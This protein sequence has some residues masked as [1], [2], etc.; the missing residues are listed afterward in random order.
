MKKCFI[1]SLVVG[2]HFDNPDVP[3]KFPRIEDYDYFLFTNLSP[4]KLDTSWDIKDIQFKNDRKSITNSRF[5]KFQGWKILKDYDIII[6]CDAWLRPIDDINIWKRV[7]K[8][9]IDSE[10]GLV[11][12]PHP[13]HNCPF[14]EFNDILRQKKDSTENLIKTKKLFE[15]HK[16]EKGKGLW[17]G[18]TFCYYTHNDKVKTLFN[19]VW[20]FLSSEEYTHRDQPTM[21]LSIHVTGISPLRLP[22]KYR[23]YILE[24]NKHGG[25]RSLFLRSGH[26][27]VHSYG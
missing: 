17:E 8:L 9:T 24:G 12:S 4:E 19:K 25:M 26:M 18:G 20:E 1:S 11:Q 15:K 13:S 14:D 5:V 6:Y 3:G 16:L 10:N 7:I 21:A 27:G 22:C 2:S 23:C